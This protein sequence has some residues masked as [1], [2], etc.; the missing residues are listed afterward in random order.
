MLIKGFFIKMLIAFLLIP[1]SLNAQEKKLI[2]GEADELVNDPQRNKLYYQQLVKEKAISNALNNEFGTISTSEN[3][4]QLSNTQGKE[5]MSEELFK[6]YIHQFPNGIWLKD[7]EVKFNEYEE[8]GKIWM[9]CTIEGWAIEI[10]NPPINFLVKTLDKVDLKEETTNFNLN[11]RL[12]LYFKAP[13]DGYL[14]VYIDNFTETQCLLP[15]ADAKDRNFAVS[16]NK[17]YYLF[18]TK[19]DYQNNP[20]AVDEYIMYT[21]ENIEID[22]LYIIFSTEKLQ[23]TNL[24]AATKELPMSLSS[25]D[26]YQW[27]QEIRL[28]KAQTQ[29][30]IIDINIR[31]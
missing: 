31:K 26:F 19:Y 20:S 23:E 24:N 25:K 5:V 15:Y 13:S 12:Y 4:S 22:R 2:S 10:Q 9:K 27:I 21:D 18:S 30:K 1:C 16:A 29:I 8:K 14:Y 7:K 17:E 11:Q 6:N 28:W 3:I